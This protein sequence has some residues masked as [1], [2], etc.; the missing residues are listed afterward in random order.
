MSTQP[1]DCSTFF[2]DDSPLAIA[3]PDFSVREEQRLLAERIANALVQ[4][5]SAALEAPTGTGKTLAYLVPTLLHRNRVIISVG[6]RTLQDHLWQGEYQKLRTS[7]PSLRAITVLK[8]C[9]NYL[10]RWRLQ[11]NLQTAQRWVTEHSQTIL[12]WLAQ[13][14]SGEIASIPLGADGRS[15]ARQWLSVTADQCLGQ[16]C[17]QFEQCFFQR[18]RQNALQAEVLL[19]NHTLLLSDNRLFEK[20][21]GALLPAVDAIVVDEAHQLP[22]MLVRYN[23]EAMEGYRLQRWIRQLR[24]L[25]GTELNL[26]PHL[27]AGLQQLEH[28]WGRIQ[29]SIA[30]I[31]GEG[32]V[33]VQATSLVPLLKLLLALDNQLKVLPFAQQ[34][35]DL[36]QG[37]LAQWRQMLS[38]AI[39]SEHVIHADINGAWLRLVA[40]RVQSPFASLNCTESTWIFLSA[41]L[42]V[43]GAF[44]YFKRVLELPALD[45][46]IFA[47]PL[48]W[49]R[50]A[51]LW[52]PDTLPEPG[53][54][55]FMA[56]WVETVLQTAASLDGGVL[57]L[58]SSFDAVTLAAGFMPER[59]ERRI[60]VHQPDSDRQLLLEQFRADPQ[61]ILLAT[62]SFWEGIDVVG[63]SLRCIA[64]DKLPFTPPDDILALAWKHLAAQQGKNVFTDYMVPQ[65]VT[66]LRQGVGRLLRSPDDRGLVL[67]GDTRL[68]KKAYGYRFLSSLPDLPLVTNPEVVVQFLAQQ[69]L[70]RP[71][72]DALSPPGGKLR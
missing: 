30:A 14:R 8:G 59:C 47:G 26:F 61:S 41:T 52:I 72:S 12:S 34:Q 17:S 57:M 5:R 66:R 67:L 69:G 40:G 22:D 63:A 20:G 16:R 56:R 39:T 15:Q 42:A 29:G 33:A 68:L 35:L 32:V 1:P 24:A 25:C 54:E 2:S 60:L 38:H 37:A 4:R 31:A 11:E 18:A 70:E 46:Q 45:V 62:G 48:D 44:D 28:I 19:I 21:L 71:V 13:T 55:T 10:C 58:F 49:P 3:W 7:V 23:T 65:A 64:I 53:D 36:L 27:K 9:E 43:E 6:N 50:Q 51:L